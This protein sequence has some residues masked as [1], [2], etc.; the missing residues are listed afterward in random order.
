MPNEKLMMMVG[1]LEVLAGEAEELLVEHPILIFEDPAQKRKVKTRIDAITSE[2]AGIIIGIQDFMKTY[3]KP[4]KSES[5]DK[6]LNKSSNPKS[7]LKLLRRI[8]GF[9]KAQSYQL[10]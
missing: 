1:R 4:V 10:I 6:F 9:L 3:G 2:A 5:V 8:A 7:S